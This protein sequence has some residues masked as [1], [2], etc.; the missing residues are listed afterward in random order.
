M[1]IGFSILADGDEHINQLNKLLPSLENKSV[2]ISTN[3]E[4]KILNNN[5]KILINKQEFNYNKKIFPLELALK[6]NNVV[7]C[8]DTDI[9]FVK[10]L[11]MNELNNLEDGLYVFWVGKTQMYKNKKTSLYQLFNN[12]GEIGLVKYVESLKT[13][14]ATIDNLNFFDEFFF[15]ISI[16]DE[17]TKNNF[18]N[19]W[20]TIYESTKDQ[21][22]TDRHKHKLKG[23]CESLIISLVCDKCGLK[24]IENNPIVKKLS[25][26]VIHQPT[27][28]ETKSIL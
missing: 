16:N 14:G 22:P 12:E 18:I 26:F 21:Q 15:I 28:T 1:S 10:N 19:T 23:A 27:T 25:I 6:E 5:Y 8:L 4:T 20:K 7:V 13:F 3:D 11:E 24:I 17:N 2:Y 9:R